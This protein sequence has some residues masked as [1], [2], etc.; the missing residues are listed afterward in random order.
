MARVQNPPSLEPI[1][2]SFHVYRAFWGLQGGQQIGL[3]KA[4]TLNNLNLKNQ[5]F[6]DFELVYDVEMICTT[7]NFHQGKVLIIC[8]LKRRI[9]NE[10]IEI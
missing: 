6:W 8:T 4:Y 2:T 7:L 9:I 5:L 1:R 3:E 10:Q